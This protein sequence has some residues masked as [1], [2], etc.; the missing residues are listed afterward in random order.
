MAN[1]GEKLD[2]PYLP[3]PLLLEVGKCFINQLWPF[4]CMSRTSGHSAG[5]SLEKVLLQP[6]DITNSGWYQLYLLVQVDSTSHVQWLW[7][8]W[9]I[10]DLEYMNC[11][12]YLHYA[13]RLHHTLYTLDR[14]TLLCADQLYI[15]YNTIFHWHPVNSV[16]HGHI[17]FP[18]YTLDRLYICLRN[19]REMGTIAF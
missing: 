13:N 19:L 5:K 4:S 11:R 1:S 2:F 15:A 3:T 7:Y 9:D 16:F 6:S 14:L 18:V 17:G 12:V 10:H 8:V